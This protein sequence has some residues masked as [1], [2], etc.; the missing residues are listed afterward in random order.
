MFMLTFSTDSAPWMTDW[1]DNSTQTGWLT[2]RYRKL[3]QQYLIPD[4][5]GSIGLVLTELG[6][7]GGC[8]SNTCTSCGPNGWQDFQQ[9]WCNNGGSCN[10]PHEYSFQLEWYDSLMIQDDYVIGAAI[11]CLEI[12]GWASWQLTPDVVNDLTQYMNSM[13]SAL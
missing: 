3:Y 6:I 4:K 11:Y 9:Y 8:P 10:G 12:P 13:N 5:L 2:G 1:F 7:D